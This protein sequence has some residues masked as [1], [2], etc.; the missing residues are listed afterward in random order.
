MEADGPAEGLLVDDIDEDK[1]KRKAQSQTGKVG[2]KSEQTGLDENQFSDLPGSRAKEAQESEF[3]AAVDHKSKKRSGN[4]HHCDDDRDGF[5]SVGDGEGAVED[6]DS[7][8][9]QVAIRKQQDA[10]AGGGF[11][12]G[13]SNRLQLGIWRNID[14]EIRGSGIGQ[15]TQHGLAV[16]QDAAALAGVI[17]INVGD[18]EGC[19]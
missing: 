12:D 15:I 14:R 9:A 6:T 17:V 7:F 19:L 2:Q 18:A 1:R 4:A 11:I 16:H 3:A 13:G 8:G 10:V 5:Q